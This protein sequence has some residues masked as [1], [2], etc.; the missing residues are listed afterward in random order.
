MGLGAVNEIIEFIAVLSVP[1]TN[2]G[3]YYNTALDLVFNGAGA[4]IAMVIV[5]LAGRR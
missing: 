4:V 2:V 3:G 5:A 1:D